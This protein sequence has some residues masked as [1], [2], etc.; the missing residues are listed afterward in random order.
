MPNYEL[1][2]TS[3][4]LPGY[5]ATTRCL[6]PPRCR[7]PLRFGLATLLPIVGAFA[8]TS[9]AS[10]AVVR[11]AVFEWNNQYQ[12]VERPLAGR[13]DTVPGEA[14]TPHPT[15][16]N[17]A[18]EWRIEGDDN[19]NGTVAVTFRETGTR[20]WHPALP[21]R[22]VPPGTFKD[23]DPK[24]SFI[25]WENNH[26]GSIVDLEP[27]TT[28][29]IA[30]RLHD[31]DGGTAEKILRDRTRPV[32]RAH[33]QSRVVPV[34]IR[35]FRDAATR[36]GP[37]DM[38]LLAP[39]NYGYFQTPRDGAPGRPIV[40]RTD[41]NDLRERHLPPGDRSGHRTFVLFHGFS[42][43]GRKHVHLEGILSTDTIDLFDAGD[44]VVRNVFFNT[45]HLWQFGRAGTGYVA[46]HNTSV[47]TGTALTLEGH[48]HAFARNNLFLGGGDRPRPV[49]ATI[50]PAG[51]GWD[52]DH[53]GYGAGGL[54]F[55]G[56]FAGVAFDSLGTLRAG[57]TEKHA[58]RVDPGIFAAPVLL[59][60]ALFPALLPVDLRH[61]AGGAAIDAA[62]PLPNFNDGFTGRAP[63]LGALELGAT[64]PIFGPRPVGS[65]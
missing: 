7:H 32:P 29:E 6:I 3:D 18:V 9:G 52:Y 50:G 16:H 39:G 65:N 34:T 13:D 55:A 40:Y 27:D 53:N 48:T 2:S 35:T 59:P 41:P 25:S 4:I 33:P 64:P 26:S 15:L 36:A 62:V 8:A 11:T 10:P 63:D 24:R 21:L 20:T 17:L 19:L 45:E 31:P 22:R 57:T 30:L 47:K 51:A 49:V 44:C 60:Q 58:V 42:L 28:Y 43:T 54:P 23:R 46:L 37:G 61:R 1:L 14:S 56:N 5:P 38:L 12:W